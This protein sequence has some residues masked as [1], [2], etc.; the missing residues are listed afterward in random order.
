MQTC[1]YVEIRD[2]I[3]QQHIKKIHDTAQLLLGNFE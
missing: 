1:F 3:Y 2:L